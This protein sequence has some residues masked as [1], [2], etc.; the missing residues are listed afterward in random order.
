M[1]MIDTLSS[2]DSGAYSA[3]ESNL[4]PFMHEDV[5]FYF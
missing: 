1:Q 5:C 2:E 4:G 3:R